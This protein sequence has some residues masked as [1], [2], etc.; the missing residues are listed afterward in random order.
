M[1]GILLIAIGSLVAASFYVPFKRENMGM[2]IILIN[3]DL[4]VIYTQNYGRSPATGT[5]TNQLQTYSDSTY[6]SLY[7]LWQLNP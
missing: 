6:I 1:T 3:T 2:G 7:N 5:D 4:G